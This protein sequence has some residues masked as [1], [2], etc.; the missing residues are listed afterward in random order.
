[1][2][3]VFKFLNEQ[4][5]DQYGYPSGTKYLPHPK[6][7]FKKIDP[8]TGAQTVLPGEPESPSQMQL[9]NVDGLH[10]VV[11]QFSQKLSPGIVKSLGSLV[12]AIH[13]E[14]AVSLK[15]KPNSANVANNISSQLQSFLSVLSELKK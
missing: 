14:M 11:N 7:Q 15:G 9:G 5:K 10:K 3:D 8:N 12:D 2:I 4:E 6:G 13:Q 1:M